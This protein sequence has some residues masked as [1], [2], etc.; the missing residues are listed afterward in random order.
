METCFEAMPC[1]G[2]VVGTATAAGAL[3]HPGLDEADVVVVDAGDPDV[4][5]FVRERRRQGARVLACGSAWQMPA[6]LSMMEAGAVGVL[7]K[8]SLT[9][10]AL[11]ANLQAALHGSSVLPSNLLTQLFSSGGSDDDAATGDPRGISQLTAREQDVLRLIG[12]GLGTR[13][14]AV[15]LSYSERTV[16]SVLHDAA[17]KLGARSRSHAVAHAVRAGLI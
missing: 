12:D 10:E 17:T 15:S 4:A 6:I 1:V 2:S 13:E 9:P 16:K 3:A 8:D 5:G 11:E 14:V 7:E